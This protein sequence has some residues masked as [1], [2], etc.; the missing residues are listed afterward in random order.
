[1]LRVA[2]STRRHALNMESGPPVQMTGG[3]FP[4]QER[5]MTSGPTEESTAR[6]IEAF[7]RARDETADATKKPSSRESSPSFA[8]R[9]RTRARK[10]ARASGHLR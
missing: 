8:R 2:E 4:F 1:M 6:L 9:S 3:P 7:E 10:G 5:Q